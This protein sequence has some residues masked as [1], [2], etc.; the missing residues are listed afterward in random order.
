[1]PAIPEE[2]SRVSYERRTH[3]AL[4][5]GA[6]MVIAVGGDGTAGQVASGFF[7]NGVN[8]FPKV[9]FACIPAGTA[10][11]FYRSVSTQISPSRFL[12]IGTPKE[13]DVMKIQTEKDLI[14][15]LNT[16]S[17][18]ITTKIIEHKN[19]LPR[20]VPS[21]INYLLPTLRS[22]SS[23]KS[24]DG[25]VEIDQQRRKGRVMALFLMKGLYGG[26][27]M[28]FGEEGKHDSGKFYL[29][30]VPS[31]SLTFFLK[32]IFTL[33]GEGLRSVSFVEKWEGESFSCSN[34][35]YSVVEVD[36]QIYRFD[37]LDVSLLKRSLRVLCA[38]E[39]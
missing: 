14:Y 20:W 15:G 6:K 35:P 30:I 34:S 11:D 31:V 21:S 32:N 10:C 13:L 36:G 5:N 38:P 3:E 25:E 26:G 19:R 33:Y 24:K 22:I 27:A 1:M 28:R 29:S 16:L 17:L 2:L 4:K 37:R 8:I 18:G 39:S 9:I 7:D 23:W 12:E